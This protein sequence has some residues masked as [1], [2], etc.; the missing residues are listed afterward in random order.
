MLSLFSNVDVIV[1]IWK[2]FV[3]I[4]VNVGCMQSCQCFHHFLAKSYGISVSLL[5]SYE[6]GH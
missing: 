2:K 3:I 5:N 1:E 6:L 4:A